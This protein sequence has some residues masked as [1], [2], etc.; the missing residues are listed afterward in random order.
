MTSRRHPIPSLKDHIDRVAHVV[1]NVSDL[2]RS[3]AFYESVTPLRVVARMDAPRQS[4]PALGIDD[5]AFEGYVMDDGSGDP[6]GGPPTQIHLVRWT[7]PGPVGR[8]YPAFWH[9]GLAKLA[10][11]TPSAPAKLRQLRELGIAT[12][13]PLIYRGYV[14]IQDPDG[15]LLSFAGSHTADLPHGA[16]DPC[17]FERLIHT[18]PS[19]RDVRRSRRLYEDVLGLRAVGEFI[20]CEPV[21]A[22]LGPG[23]DHAQVEAYPYVARGG[24]FFLDL[25]QFHHPRPTTETLTP[26]AEAN[27]LGIVRVGFEVDD[28]DAAYDALVW[29][30]SNGD[31]PF[32]A[33]APH[34]W[35]VGAPLGRRK[36]AVFGDHDGIQFELTERPSFE[37]TGRCIHPD[38]SDPLPGV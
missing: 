31:L 1:V 2:E 36:V 3:R 38:T 13:N 17:L 32:P 27:H 19:V 18:N 7:T 35:D 21:S 34:V 25:A 10:F 14:S 4:F 6:T 29:A 24:G 28:V 11:R 23:A 15:V 37:P 12:T 5:G 20:A 9:T 33:A 16:S 30:A 8:P 22:S 26:Y